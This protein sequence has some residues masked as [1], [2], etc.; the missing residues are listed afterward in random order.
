LE[1]SPNNNNM[2]A[3]VCD[4]GDVRIFDL[5]TS[6]ASLQN[7]S[8]GGSCSSVSWCS[9]DP[10]LIAAC[11]HDGFNV[12]DTRML[13]PST[14]DQS[15]ILWSHKTSRNTPR[16]STF[17][18]QVTWAHSETPCL[19]TA[20]TSSHLTW[21]DGLTGT[22]LGDGGKKVDSKDTSPTQTTPLPADPLPI[23]C[24]LLSMPS[25]RGILTANRVAAEQHREPV[26][27]PATIPRPL[28]SEFPSHFLLDKDSEN[29]PDTHVEYVTSK[30][31]T[32]VDVTDEIDN[33]D[34]LSTPIWINSFPRFFF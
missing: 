18:N 30:I 29:K 27:G 33:P 5:R 34:L 23:S 9:S 12:W 28:S 6:S 15:S 2:I 21:W 16:S 26:D 32:L 25:G 24:T 4:Q 1:W 3:T 14:N 19:I 31:Q 11:N 17:V 8:I 22:K 20:S 10:N 7:L 13:V